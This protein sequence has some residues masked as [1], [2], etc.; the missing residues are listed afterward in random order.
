M[1]PKTKSIL[2]WVSIGLLALQFIAAGLGKLT[3][4]TES[5]FIGWGYDTTFMYV[6]GT[7]EVLGAIGLFIKP[8]RTWAALGLI[9]LMVGAA[10]THVTH[11][12]MMNLLHNLVIVSIAVTVIRLSKA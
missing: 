6:I 9:G 10:Y 5:A 2:L 1:S 4:A 12:E 11:D 3:G 7:L 8:L